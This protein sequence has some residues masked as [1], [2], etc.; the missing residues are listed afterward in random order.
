MYE[1]FEELCGKN[2][3]TPYQV[4]VATGVA[5][6]T[7][8]MWKKGKYIPKADKVQKIANFFK[9]PLSYFMGDETE[10]RAT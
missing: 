6:S 9:V 10:N 2:N 1:K 8:T 3:A 4:S 5:T 7:L